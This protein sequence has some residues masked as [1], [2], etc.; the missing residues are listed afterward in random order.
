[1]LEEKGLGVF[2]Y[3]IGSS[4]ISALLLLLLLF[5]LLLP[6]NVESCCRIIKL[7]FSQTKTYFFYYSGSTPAPCY[8]DNNSEW[9][10]S[11]GSPSYGLHPHPSVNG[12]YLQLEVG[13][14]KSEGVFVDYNFSKCNNYRVE[15]VLK[16]AN[17]NSTAPSIEIY[18]TNELKEK[19]DIT[20]V[21]DTNGNI[22]GV[23]CKLAD[24]PSV[25]DKEAVSGAALPTAGCSGFWGL[26]ER[27]TLYIPFQNAYWNPIKDYTQLWI[28]SKS[29]SD[30][31][32]FVIEKITIVDGGKVES[33]PPTVPGNLRATSITSN[34]ITIQWDPS[35]DA[36]GIEEYEVYRNSTK[37]ISIPAWLHTYKFQGL[38]PCT[39]YDNIRVRARD[40]YCNYS[41]MASINVKTKPIEHVTLS[42]PIIISGQPY[43]IE[44]GDYIQF[45]PGFSVTI[46]SLG[47]YFQAIIGCK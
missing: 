25:F 16:D 21:F 39:P 47:G 12:N 9:K 18:A 23:I 37:V 6:N 22:I 28:S 34:S 5:L 8:L 11:H 31:G 19:T 29:R 20:N 40:V 26:I 1:M 38:A 45:N 42:T 14:D 24:P 4:G 32:A 41:P 43:I 36:S 46:D 27:C 17:L 2:W 44:A 33:T 7:A 3:K 15:I 30:T 35:Y 10:S 13:N